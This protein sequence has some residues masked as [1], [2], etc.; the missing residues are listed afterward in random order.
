M[1]SQTV[2]D[3]LNQEDNQALET[4]IKLEPLSPEKEKLLFNRISQ[5]EPAEQEEVR[6]LFREYGGLFALDDLD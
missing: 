4:K 6:E 2:Q 1:D 5:W 3:V